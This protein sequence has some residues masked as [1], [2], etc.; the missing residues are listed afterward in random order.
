MFKYLAIILS[1]SSVSYCAYENTPFD[2]K[3]DDLISL[4]HLKNAVTFALKNNLKVNFLFPEYDLPLE[5]NALI[6]EVEH[7]KIVP[8]QLY[9][10][11]QDSILVIQ[12]KN[13]LQ[14][15]DIKGLKDG[16]VILRVSKQ[17]LPQ[18][19]TSISMLA[20][21]CT[22]INLVLT[23]IEKYR[24]ED[25]DEYASQLAQISLYIQDSLS[26]NKIPELNFLTDRMFLAQMNNC[27]AGLSHLSVAPNG[28]L[29][30]CPAFYYHNEDSTLGEIKNDVEIK[31]K[32][33]LELKYAPICRI[34]DTYQ[35]RR[36]VF[37]NKKLTSEINTPSYQQCRLSHIERE[38]SRLMSIALKESKNFTRQIET[39][40]EIDYLDP[41]EIAQKHKIEI[42]A[43][44]L[45]NYANT[46]NENEIGGESN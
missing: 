36:C 28:K 33:L 22:R 9:A 21:K 38:A 6:D 10:T 11:Y 31:N 4:P 27:N 40:P 18:L 2:N 17:H 45:I 20:P 41:F 34:C 14:N 12:P 5:Y 1:K 46:K 37:L 30:L 7:I 13:L 43:F 35:C 8:L 32:Q 39:I 29:Y 16:N 24:D 15:A 19:H 3:T 42:S 25:L 44:K 23:D 26:G